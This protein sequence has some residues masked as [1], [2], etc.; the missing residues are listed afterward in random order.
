MDTFFICLYVP[1][2]GC[3]YAPGSRGFTV[4]VSSAGE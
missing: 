3:A 4:Y 2:A 1:V